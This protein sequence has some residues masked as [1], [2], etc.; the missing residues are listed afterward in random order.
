MLY[1]LVHLI[2]TTIAK[3]PQKIPAIQKETIMRFSEISFFCLLK[4]NILHWI[5][6]FMNW[7]DHEFPEI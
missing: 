4:N 6:Q 5:L 1:I 2:K 7:L 3:Y